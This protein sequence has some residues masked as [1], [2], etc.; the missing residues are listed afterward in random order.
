MTNFVAVQG[1]MLDAARFAMQITIDV[2]NAE[3]ALKNLELAAYRVDAEVFRDLIQ[4]ELAKI[5]LYRAQLEGQR[6]RGELNQQQVTI[7][8]ER[9]RAL[10]SLVEIYKAQVDG[11][12]A[13]AEVNLSRTQAFVA[14]VSAYSERVKAYETEWEAFGKQL[15]GDVTQYRRYELATEVFGNRV[16]IWS[17]TNTN[18]IDQNR[19][20]LSEKE[21]D[22]AA[23]RARL[24]KVNTVLQAETQRFDA[25]VRFYGQQ[26]EKYRADAAVESIISEGNG[27]VFQ[28]AL[29]QETQRTT[30]ALE[31]ARLRI[32]QA[33]EVAKILISKNDT[34]ARVGAQLAAGAMSAM[35]VS[36]RIDSSLSQ[37]LGCETNFNYSIRQ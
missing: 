26:I 24:D 25:L 14:Q 22:I 10:L 2:F 11:A 34:I 9:V 33:E 36:A 35:S 6:I 13:K 3:V 19:L 37:R 20:K 30:V 16:K 29:Q 18:L 32:A 4:A 28:L 8:A 21:L 31:N 23:Y 12:K 15:E 27:R 1:Q 5:E 7:Y 17:D